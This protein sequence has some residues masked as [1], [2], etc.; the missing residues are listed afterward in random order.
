MA[1]ELQ[2]MAELLTHREAEAA[3]RHAQLMACPD[4]GKPGGTRSSEGGEGGEALKPATHTNARG[5]PAC[6]QRQG[7]QE[8]QKGKD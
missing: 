5:A 1:T 8:G 6:A 4:G 7:P 2:R 3:A